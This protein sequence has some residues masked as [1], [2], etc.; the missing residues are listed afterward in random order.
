MAMSHDLSDMLA[1]TVD[2]MLRIGLIDQAAHRETTQRHMASGAVRG[3]Y[4]DQP[5]VNP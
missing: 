1:E 3:G 4:A 5:G 2:D